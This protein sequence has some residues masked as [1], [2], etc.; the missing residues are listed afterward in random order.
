MKLNRIIPILALA[1]TFLLGTSHDSGMTHE[2]E[3]QAAQAM[4][5]LTQ[6]IVDNMLQ[7]RESVN[8]SNRSEEFITNLQSSAPGTSV[9]IQGDLSPTYASPI[10]QL[11]AFVSMDNQATWDTTA[12]A[13][14]G[15]AGYGNTWEC[16]ASTPGGND[17]AW[18]LQAKVNIS[19]DTLIATQAPKNVNEV[20]PPGDNLLAT[21]ATDPAWDQY[22]TPF[23]D[24]LDISG[25]YSNDSLYFRMQNG[26]GG[27]PLW[28][29]YNTGPFWLYGIGLVNPLTF[30]QADTI[31]IYALGYAYGIY[32]T[33]HTGLLKVQATSSGEIV[34]Q[35][36]IDWLQN[37]A[38][39]LGN[40]SYY[41]AS[42]GGF[43]DVQ[44]ILADVTG[45]YLSM[46][47][48]IAPLLADADFGAWPNSYGGLIAMGMIAS[49]TNDTN[50]GATFH[51]AAT[52]GILI[53]ETQFQTGNVAPA[54]SS[55]AFDDVTNQLS[56]SYLDSDSNLPV[57]K[58][59]TI[60]GR[61]I[62]TMTPLA[63]T[64]GTGAGF[65][66]DLVDTTPG[67]Y[68]A[69][70]DFQDGAAS[71]QLVLDFTIPTLNCNDTA[72][73]NFG[74]LGDCV[75]PA[76][77]NDWCSGDAGGPQVVDCA[78]VCGGTSVVDECGVC[79]GPGI[80]PGECDC[81]GSVLDC[82]GVCGGTAVVDACGVCDGPGLNADGCC[83]TDVPDCAGVCGGTSALDVCG[84]CDG[85]G[86]NADGC[87]GNDVP[88]C[89]GVCGGT[90][91]VDVCGVCDGPGLNADGCC[92]NDTPDCAGVCGGTSALDVCGVCDG[93][94][95]NA[96]G[97]CGNDTPDCAGVCGGTSVI[98][99]CSDCVLPANFDAAQDCAGV[100]NG[101]AYT[102]DCGVC[103]ADPGNDN[104]CYGCTNSGALNYDPS[105][106]IDDGSCTYP[107][108]VTLYFGAVD[109]VNNTIEIWLNNPGP[110]ATGGFQFGVDGATITGASGGTAQTYGF[111]VSVGG[112]VLGVQIGLPIPAGDELLTVLTYTPGGPINFCL[113]GAVVTSP[114]PPVS[115]GVN[116]G[117]CYIPGCT[118]NTAC[119]YD[120]AATVDDGSCVA[121]QGCNDWC[122]GD[123]GASEQ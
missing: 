27:Y 117:P 103:D 88:D 49:V 36:T 95:L 60:G 114:A 66:Y 80:L 105:A 24:I 118:D 84:V 72:A 12:C 93:P 52:P 33:L 100:C 43:V 79:N 30:F 96:D 8:L 54:L 116:L 123:P 113:S 69:T 71:N 61:E 74:A 115:F 16:N 76:G 68:T 25:T 48:P 56:V 92:G 81:A 34:Q 65:V 110:L 86:L 28:G 53:L 77:C 58:G 63:H 38:Y 83:G 15:T 32:G 3:V 107:Q 90:S 106:T 111:F 18:Y 26:G 59:V 2:Q 57:A 99:D 89:A 29:S 85:P 70:F 4:H 42:I 50:Q 119:N 10:P 64:Y 75:Y 122:A 104:A 101:T 1:A 97:C 102:D 91:V 23:T 5:Q 39:L 17:M 45:D 6:Q 67:N 13:P 82:L 41:D 94:G 47:M 120:L 121:P 109:E 55:A 37:E 22:G 20:F 9:T 19:G 46:A 11:N 62:G 21:L 78:G 7:Y 44:E 73:C 14:L 98:D 35:F 87:C 108:D 31:T 51:D 40:Y 112:Q